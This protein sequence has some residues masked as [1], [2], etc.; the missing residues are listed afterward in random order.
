MQSEQ[1][2]ATRSSKALAPMPAGVLSTG[3]LPEAEVIWFSAADTY[4][5]WLTDQTDIGNANDGYFYSYEG[6]HLARHPGSAKPA[7]TYDLFGE[8]NACCEE[9]TKTLLRR[10]PRF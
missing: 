2:G 9:A 10:A 1:Y 3:T 8:I 5:I 4:E 7:A 6:A